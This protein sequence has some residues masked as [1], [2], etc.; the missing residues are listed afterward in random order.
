MKA[1][2]A[3]QYLSKFFTEIS[4]PSGSDTEN[5]NPIAGVGAPDPTVYEVLVP[6][7]TRYCITRVHFVIRDANCAGGK[8]GGL[9]A[10]T[11]GV[12]IQVIDNDAGDTVLIDFLDG[13][14]I[15]LNDQ[16]D[17]LSG[18]DVVIPDTVTAP[19]V[20]IRWTLQKDLGGDYLELTAGQR[21]RITV[22]D[23]LSGLT[24]WRTMAK[25]FS[26]AG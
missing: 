8:F 18:V 1:R 2:K 4:G 5:M 20:P 25:G 24:E 16:F 13:K 14:T 26:V 19:N 3:Q 7:D 17:W 21:F 10:L 15:K 22:Q 11:N 23:D 12:K 6:A 9:A